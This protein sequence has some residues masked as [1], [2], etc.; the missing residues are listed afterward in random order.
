[1]RRS[2]TAQLTLMLAVVCV[3]ALSGLVVMTVAVG[4]LH[5]AETERADSSAAIT[6]ANQLEQAVLDL[7]TGLRGYLLG[8]SSVF[9]QP[10]RAALR[11][12]PQLARQL[13]ARTAGDRVSHSMSLSIAGAIRG[14][15]NGWT[16]QTIRSA[17]R[18]LDAARRAEAGGGGKHRV[19][20]M[21]AQF[22]T[23]LARESRIHSGQVE[24]VS[25]LSRLALVS[26]LIAVVLFVLM[27]VAFALRTQMCV[28]APLRRLAAAVAAITGGDLSVRVP[29]GGAAEVGSLVDGFN[30]MAA[31]LEEQ[32][33]SL[34]D[35]HDELE[36][37]KIELQSA[38]ASVEER[39]RRIE[40]LRRFGDRLAVEDSVES[41]AAAVLEAMADAAGCEVGAAYMLDPDT[42]VFDV[43]ATRGLER[44][45][46]AS[47]VAVGDGLPGRA[48]AERRPVSASGGETTMRVV[49]LAHRTPIR[50][51]LHVPILHGERTVG[52]IGLGRLSARP[53]SE[54]SLDVLRALAERAGVDCAQA[55]STR[56]LHRTAHELHAILETTDQGVYGVDVSGHITLVNRAA[57]EMTGFSRDELMGESSHSLLHHTR[58]DGS[59]YPEREC[60]VLLT[61][62]S[63]EGERI[64]DEV[65]W[66]RDGTSFPVE[67]SVYPLFERDEITGAVVTFFDRTAHRQAQRHRDTQHALTRVFAETPSLAEARPRMLAAVCRGLGF[68][69]GLTWDPDDDPHTLRA[70][71]TYSTTGYEA[72]AAALASD[73]LDIAGT[74]AER[75]IRRGEPVICTDLNHEPP[76][77]HGLADPRVR[78]AIGLPVL[79]RGGR[80][81]AVAEFFASRSATEE[82]LIDTLRAVGSQVAQHVE[83]QRA[84]EDSQRVKDQIV[85]NVSHELRTPLTAIDGWVEVL[86]DEEPGPLTDDQRRFLEIVKRNS[87]RLMRLVGDLLVAGQIEAGKLKLEL[88]HVDMA[89]LA[90]ET[91]ELHAPGAASKEIALSISAE[92]HAVVRGD[93]QRLGQLLSNL[94]GNAI[95]FTPERGKVELRVQ[96]QDDVCRVS[97]S[98][99][100]IGIAPDERDRLFERFYRAPGATQRGITGTGLGLAISKAIAESHD[101]RLVLEDRAGP[102][103]EFVVE[104]PLSA[105]EEAL[106]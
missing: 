44:S 80:L 26:G 68:D 28:V 5:G 8:G 106:T 82:G 62:E 63:G 42:G 91:A 89:E 61:F 76:R 71:A 67:Y 99:T 27:I 2:L 40:L 69:V 50:H 52:V 16:I 81:V 88:G 30:R 36:G 72:L 101:G 54:A 39:N 46:L 95:K 6:T 65:F 24:R 47:A 4:D 57:L 74:L 102:G 92:D 17:Q 104:L 105:R 45:Q 73:R 29:E 96:A 56:Q 21:R 100:G 84:E 18:N 19:D 85:A 3:V 83:R 37:Q 86:L 15:V 53:F 70:V 94:V 97:V 59:P 14:Y 12:Y 13:E 20:A 34:A 87:D 66:R 1:M 31:G 48:L 75:A 49:G 58:A 43:A 77:L 51:E 10:Y 78:T 7:E 23:L 25:A 35:H 55:L 98:D 32:R 60:P 38:L 22:A 11:T 93:R 9:L 103:T 90:Q 41:V 64:T 33:D 79:S